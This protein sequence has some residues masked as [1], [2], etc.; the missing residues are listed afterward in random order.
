[1]SQLETID[2]TS[3]EYLQI[4]P[5]GADGKALCYAYDADGNKVQTLPRRFYLRVSFTHKL[6]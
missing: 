2:A 6:L 1:M 5:K 3:G 4:R